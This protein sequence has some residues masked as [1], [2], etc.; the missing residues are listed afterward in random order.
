MHLSFR[1]RV[2]P[3][4]AAAIV[5]AIGISLGQ[6]QTRRG[7]EKQAIENLLLARQSAP[8]LQLEQV[9]TDAAEIA[10]RR[11]RLHGSFER[12]W[13]VYLDNRPYDGRAGFYLAMPFRMAASGQHVLVLRGWL[14]RDVAD[15]TRLPAVDTPAGETEIEGVVRT[16]I[17][18]VM[19]LGQPEA[20]RPGAIVQ[21]LDPAELSAASD[22]ALPALVIEQ[23]GAAQDGLV[24]D[25]PR[26]SSGI[27]KHRGYAFQWYGLAALACVFFVVTGFGRGRKQEA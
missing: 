12:E 11:V 8:V 22:L 27:D 20:L 1:F 2:V 17:G 16:G 25:W 6:W 21:N 15:R 19:Q 7:D 10:F 26:P 13:P 23:T 24:R 4:I 9:P 5:A 18:R 3:F 14:P